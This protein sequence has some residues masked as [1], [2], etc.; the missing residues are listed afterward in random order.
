MCGKKA[1]KNQQCW[2]RDVSCGNVCGQK[3]KCGVHFC[4]KPCHRKGQC[5]DD[6]GKA[7]TQ[8]CG[9]EKKICGHPD[10]A[11]CHAPFACKEMKPCNSK[12]FITCE[13]QAQKQEV[14]CGASS[15]TEGNTLKSLPCTEECARLERNRRLAV[16]LNIDQATHIDGGDHIPFSTATLDLFA[17]HSKWGQAQEREFRVFAAS[18][19]EKRLR[20]KPMSAQQRSFIHSLAEDFGLDSESVDPEPH[21]HVM[22]WKTPRFVS[23]P[24][25]TLADALR[26]RQQAQRSVNA[27][28][29]APD[30]EG[31]PP[32]SMPKTFEPFNSFRI[33]KPR[34]GLTIEDIRTEV[35]AVLHTA[36]PFTFDIEFLPSEDIVLKAI[37]RILSAQDL[38]RMLL[39]LKDPLGTQIADRG[40]GSMQ[41]CTTDSSLNITRFE[42]DGTGSDGW[43]RVA[44]KKFAPRIA[45]QSNGYGSTNAF[46]ALSGGKVTFAKKTL[47]VKVAKAKLAPVVDDWEAAEV[48]EEERERVAYASANDGEGLGVES[49]QYPLT[50]LE[51]VS[52]DE[53]V[54]AESV[55]KVHETIDD[56]AETRDWA[57]EAEQAGQT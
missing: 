2:L 46:S 34:F 35:D 15:T 38:E 14:K 12:I 40:Y 42:S 24:N 43:S 23:A 29:N 52:G 39:N 33:T 4:R 53:S 51:G 57:E 22:I 45:L 37:S 5:E 21:R 11:P 44:A 18:D 48:A 10:E 20:F 30:N 6:G 16:A 3:L 26:V 32:K 55:L 8:P 54:V 13:C 47:P 25:K 49:P 28:L 9:K 1:L 50:P 19:D 27:S 36:Y 41:F 56:G 7:C 31:G 17:A